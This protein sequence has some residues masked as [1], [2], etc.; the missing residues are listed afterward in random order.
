MTEFS[1]IAGGGTAVV[2]H[3]FR[4]A[5]DPTP[6]QREALASHCGA[7]RFA[8]N[9]GLAQV[10][11]RLDKRQTDPSVQ[12]P[13]T[14]PA[15]RR[16]WNRA[17]HEVA[18]WWAENSKE[19]YSSGL[20]GLARALKNWSCSRNGRGT[21]RPV[22]FPR[23]KKRGSDRDTCRFTTGTIR[24]L[25]DRKHVQLPRIGI[26]KS[27]E[28]TRKLARR[29][30]QG[31][32]RVLAAS[33]S[34]QADRWYVSFTC[35]VQRA[36]RSPRRP[37][38]VVGVD[39]G[40]RHLAVLSTGTSVAN[41]A[42]LASELRR[43]RRLNRQ[44]ARRQGYVAPDGSAQRPSAGWQQ[45]RVR[46][47]RAHAR[48]ANVRRDGLHKLTSEL[49]G[50]YGTVVVERLNVA[51]LMRNRP[52]ARPIADAGWGELRRQLGYKTTWAGGRLVQAGT[53]YP[54]TK[55]CSRC[56]VVK[57]KLPLAVRVFQCVVCGL[58]IDRDLNAA[59]NLAK[60]AQAVAESGPETRNACGGDVRP[61][62]FGQTL[63]KREASSG[64]AC[65][66]EA[67][68]VE[69]QDST[70][71]DRSSV[72]DGYGAVPVKA[73]IVRVPRAQ[74]SPTTVAATLW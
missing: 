43:L 57:A 70:A 60:L 9:W 2:T 63:L 65:P 14:L 58:V 55:T 56:G 54:S 19:A 47:A 51:G 1:S 46:V 5:L 67:G 30:E 11:Q 69:P 3:A 62:L 25:P 50:T 72:A 44:L 10:K 37:R 24:V 6:R 8:H 28:S 36:M 71:A 53:F 22:G 66:G 38:A 16:E 18:P 40:I 33:I 42:P 7:A 49:A 68:T 12:V 20:D 17:K 41:P 64:P 4:F 27:H 34:R 21:G 15:L 48:V 13:W 31:T 59:V 35:E 61:G 32:A 39:V 26:L 45:A 73:K 52:L 23:F 74:V 29:L